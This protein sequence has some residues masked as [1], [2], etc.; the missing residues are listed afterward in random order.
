MANSLNLYF[1]GILENFWTEVWTFGLMILHNGMN[2]Y[3][4]ALLEMLYFVFLLV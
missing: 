2:F 4:P 3:T 1:K